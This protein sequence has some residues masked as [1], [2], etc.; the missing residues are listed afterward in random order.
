MVFK[1][2]WHIWVDALGQ[3]ANPTDKNHSDYVAIVRTIIFI[4]Y[5][6]TNIFIV[7]GIIRHW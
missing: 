5:L 2:I 3:K 1:K 7:A 4:T 6:T